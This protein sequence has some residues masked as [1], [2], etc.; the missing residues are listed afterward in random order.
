MGEVGDKGHDAEAET[1]LLQEDAEGDQGETGRQR[2]GH[3]DVEHFWQRD[4]ERHRPQPIAE[5]VEVDAVSAEQATE[6]HAEGTHRALGEGQF[7]WRE[8]QSAIAPRV[9][10]K[11]DAGAVEEPFGEEEEQQEEHLEAEIA[12]VR[13]FAEVFDQQGLVVVAF[14]HQLL[15]ERHEDHG[16]ID[17]QQEDE[18]PQQFADRAPR[19]RYAAMDH[20]QVASHHRG[21][22]QRQGKGGAGGG[23]PCGGHL[24]V[25]ATLGAD[26]EVAAYPHVVEGCR[27]GLGVEEEEE[28]GQPY[29][30]PQHDPHGQEDQS[31]QH[32]GVEDEM[33]AVGQLAGEAA[34][35]R[36]E[37]KG[38]EGQGAAEE[39]DR[40]AHPHAVEHDGHEGEDG[41]IGYAAQQIERGNPREVAFPG[42]CSPFSYQI[43]SLFHHCTT[44]PY[45]FLFL[46]N[47]LPQCLL[48]PFFGS[49]DA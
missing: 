42:P 5:T 7:L 32:F 6:Q 37:D 15:A 46:A 45:T 17:R 20:L 29:F 48:T 24:L 30:Q 2:V 1:K 33:V 23:S 34:Q 9:D 16:M 18:A 35:Q 12:T 4:G 14:A 41:D 40:I 47:T 8:A 22:A 39:V 19:H 31:H 43:A 36:A 21:N 10:K 44:F 27:Q 11:Q 49:S 26:H 13:Q 3:Q 28:G 38:D 25:E